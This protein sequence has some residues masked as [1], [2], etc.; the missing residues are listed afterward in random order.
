M[1]RAFHASRLFVDKWES[2]HDPPA[3]IDATQRLLAD[4][5]VQ[6]GFSPLAAVEAVHDEQQV[7]PFDKF[8]QFDSAVA[9]S[10]R[11][12]DAVEN[13]GADA[14][15][16]LLGRPHLARDLIDLLEAQPLDLAHQPVG[17]VAQDRQRVVAQLLDQRRD[18]VMRQSERREPRH[19]R[20]E[21]ARGDP[22]IAQT[23]F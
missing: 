10:Q 20:I 9:L 17:I 1:S 4:Q 8:L 23:G 15:L 7:R 14:R 2:R 11:F 16:M 6:F 13:P 18:L 19:C 21:L 3:H 12:M 22:D 5:A